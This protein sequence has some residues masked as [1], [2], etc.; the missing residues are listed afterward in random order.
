MDTNNAVLILNIRSKAI[1]LNAATKL[2]KFSFALFWI[3][4]ALSLVKNFESKSHGST[5]VGVESTLELDFFKN[6]CDFDIKF[7]EGM[8]SNHFTH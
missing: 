8:P 7:I 2:A 6:S 4:S 3:A 5:V 1:F